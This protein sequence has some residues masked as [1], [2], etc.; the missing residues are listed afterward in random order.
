MNQAAEAQPAKQ[1]RMWPTS[2]VTYAGSSETWT[3]QIH[4]VIYSTL[5]EMQKWSPAD[6]YLFFFLLPTTYLP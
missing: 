1:V 3:F 2:V 4:C 6:I 5:T